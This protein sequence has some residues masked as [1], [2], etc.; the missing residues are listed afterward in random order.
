MTYRDI[1]I[2]AKPGARV[3]R[4]VIETKPRTWKYLS[5]MSYSEFEAT[6]KKEREQMR[7]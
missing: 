3:T 4:R 1:P 2:E 5:E 6:R 7:V